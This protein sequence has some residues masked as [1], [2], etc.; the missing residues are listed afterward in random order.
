M[1]TKHLSP[2]LLTALFFFSFCLAQ[3]DNSVTKKTDNYTVQ[4][5]IVFNAKKEI[6]MMKNQL[7]WHTPALRSDKPQAI[8]EAMDSLASSIG[9]KIKNIRL[10]GLY[11]HKFQGVQDHPEVSFRSHYTA[12]YVSGDILNPENKN[13]EYQWIPIKNAVSKFYFDFIRLQT[14]PI[15]KNRK[16]IWGGTFLIIW[17]G[18]KLKGTKLIEDIYEL[19]G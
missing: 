11:T 6:L 4:F 2:F 10:G 1:N 12:D 13:I 16:K 18:E 8:R 7:G 3:S 15:L 17:E 19:G 5:L 9:L 14:A